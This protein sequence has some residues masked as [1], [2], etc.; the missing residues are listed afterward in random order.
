MS[1]K[2]LLV[3]DE[4]GLVKGLSHSLKRE[5]YDVTAAYDGDTGLGLTRE[6]DFDLLI[7][8]L[9]L[10][11][12]DGLSVCREIRKSPGIEALPI[13]ML[14]AKGDDVDKIVGLEVGADDYLS[15]P[16]NTRE[17]IA[18][19][20]ALLRRSELAQKTRGCALRIDDMVIDPEARTVAIAG[21][22]TPEL[23]AKEFDL[24]YLMARHPGRVFEREQ[25]LDRVWGM[26]HYDTRTVDVCV[27]RV[28]KKIEEDPSDPVYILTRWGVGYSFTAKR[29]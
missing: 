15:K 26:E 24:L 7:L 17:L 3:D 22:R 12:K 4:P 9:M 1:H 25:L 21:Q 2:I 6:Q 18:R 19:I 13:I 14:T 10:P 16:F 11:G 20:K 23:T 27:G 28:R 5:G 8:D 29:G